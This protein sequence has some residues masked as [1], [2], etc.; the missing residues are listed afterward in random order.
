VTRG[1]RDAPE[2]GGEGPATITH[3]E[4]SRTS[5]PI[6]LAAYSPRWSE[7]FRRHAD[8]LASV[9]GDRVVRIE[10]VGSTSVPGLVAKPT[11]DVVLEVADSAREPAY[12]LD[13]ERAGYRLRIREPEWFEH[14]MC[15]A[16]RGAVNL[17]VFSASCPETDRMV[18]F[19]DRLRSNRPDRDR[20]ACL[21]RELAERDWADV[22][23]YAAAKTD[24][25]TEILRRATSSPAQRENER[26]DP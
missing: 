22:D 14:R 23:Q 21:K 4:A 15:I 18:R 26:E 7:V 2:D 5:G 25:I 10:H 6:E 16:E 19:R 3:G 9:L 13:L 20:Y 12:L 1:Q 24:V 17:H 11:V 8:R